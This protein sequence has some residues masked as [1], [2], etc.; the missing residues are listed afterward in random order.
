MT[1]QTPYPIGTPGQP[2]GDAERAQWLSLQRVQ[3]S[4]AQDVLTQ[5]DRLRDRFTVTSYG[6]LHYP[7]DR[8]PLYA[9]RSRDWHPER[10]I[11]LVT[12]G[13]HGYETS[14]VHGALLFADEYAERFIGQVNLLVVP[15]VSPWAYE[16]IHRW[17]PHAIDPNRSFREPSPSPEAALLMQLLAPI[18]AQIALHIDLHET[19]DSDETEF[20]TALAARDGKS[21]EPGVI[22]DGFY[23]VGDSDNPQLPFQQAVISAV[24]QVTHIALA[25]ERGEILGCPVVSPGVILYKLRSLGLCAGYTDARYTTTTE[26]YPDSP[27]T[28]AAECNRAQAT[29]VCAAIEFLLRNLDTA[30]SRWESFF[31]DNKSAWDARV[32]VH[33]NSRFYDVDGFRAGKSSLTPLEERLLGD[34]SGQRL[35]HLQCHFG[36]DTLSWARKGA[37]VV[38]VDFSSKAI[39]RARELAQSVG[40]SDVARFVECNVY[41]TRAHVPE[42]FD[43][44][45]TSFGVIGWLPDLRPWAQVIKESLH[46]GGRLFLIE[47]HPYIWMSQMGP[48][49]SIRYAY[50][51]R[52]P[53]SEVGSGTYA[54]RSAKISYREHGWNHSFADVISALLAA[55]L[56]IDD[57]A[58]YDYS[59]FD[60]FPNLVRR[61]TSPEGVD[62]SAVSS[63]PT[64]QGF[65]FR[66]HPGM[67]PMMFSLQASRRD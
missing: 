18:R 10:P 51:N 1:A 48:D 66:D 30:H 64:E 20:R 31:T 58:E 34:V 54:E 41:D 14:G 50:F 56:R 24:A 62:G 35:L 21:S 40:L 27:K 38:G 13:V 2:W 46:P 63:Q 47:F 57:L 22:P 5:I 16:R 37:R 65:W 12:G 52:G 9:L 55:G 15:C 32:D 4:Y 6:E 44:V 19:T 39:E 3:R 11:V 25:D 23:V 59:P 49:L 17:N 45:Y 60:I 8:Y 26:V 53:I 43:I 7:P 67:I 61:P 33:A 29:A 42:T 28:S 36:L